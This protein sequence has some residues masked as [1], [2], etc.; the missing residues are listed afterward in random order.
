MLAKVNPP[1]P[2]T[3]EWGRMYQIAGAWKQHQSET[4]KQ[5]QKN[6]ELIP[7]IIASS[8]GNALMV[9]RVGG[10]RLSLHLKKNLQ[11]RIE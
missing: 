8:Y 2:E 4:K 1:R 3:R 11:V 9:K 5:G 7:W 6:Y 10:M